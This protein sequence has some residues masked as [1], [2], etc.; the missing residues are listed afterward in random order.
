MVFPRTDPQA[1]TTGALVAGRPG[2]HLTHTACEG[3]APV[4]AS[5][6]SATLL[7]VEGRPVRVE[8]HVSSGI[9]GFT[10]VGLPDTTCREA[11]DRVRAALL[12]SGLKWPNARMTVNLAPPGLRKVGA[13]LDLAIAAGLLAA[14]GQIPLGSLA[15]R[16][17]VGEVGLDG[18]VRSVPG[19]LP[20][21]D[22]LAEPEVVVPE[23]CTVEAQLVGRHVVRP[24]CT[25]TMLAQALA[26]RVSWPDAPEPVVPPPPPPGPDLADVRGQPAARYALEGAAAGGH[27]LLLVGPPGAGKTMLARRLPGL[28]PDLVPEHALE[29]TCIHSAAGMPLPRGGLVRRPP[30]RAPHHGASAVSLVG[31]GSHSMQPGEVSLAHRGVLFLDELGEFEPTVL[32]NLRQ[33]LEEGVIR[34]ARASAK[35]TFPARLLLVAAMNPCPCGYLGDPARECRCAASAIARYQKR[36]SGPLL[37]RIDIHLEVPRVAYEQLSAKRAGEPSAAVRARV[38]AARAAQAARFAG[39]P[40]LTNADMGPRELEQHAAPDAAGE[41]LLRAA[42]RQLHLSARSYHRVLKLAR[43]IADLAGAERVGAAHV[44][45]AL[46]YRPR[47]LNA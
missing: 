25:L 30:F 41:G 37:D 43:T 28:L 20:L 12:S 4:L 33:P 26:G 9:P 10:V 40:L 46:Q 29:A 32:D 23:G 18:S 19:A 35:V 14:S 21:I 34:V 27:H 38:E 45:E 13:G 22:A 17:F 2:R 5:V 39:T 11:R 6:R 36:I 7:G 8:V 24:V 44:A 47:Q 16:A 1:R 42:V 15:G 3:A 31:G